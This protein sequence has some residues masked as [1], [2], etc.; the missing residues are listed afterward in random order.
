MRPLQLARVHLGAVAVLCLLTLSACFLVAGL[1]R[2]LQA[3]FDAAMRDTLGRAPAEQLDLAVRSV[4]NTRADD[5]TELGQFQDRENRF[6]KVLPAPLRPMVQP[7]GSGTSHFSAK[8]FQTPVHGSNGKTFVNLGWL[9]DADKRV[10]W[11]QGRPP[12]PP[13][14]TTFEGHPITLFEV[15]VVEESLTQMGLALGQQKIIGESDYAAVKVV[16]VFRAKNPAD[17]YWSHNFDV[18]HVQLVQQPNELEPE[19]HTTTL[20]STAALTALSGADRNLEYSWVLP[21]D[22]RAAS[23]LDVPGLRAAVNDFGRVAML[24]AVGSTSQYRLDSGLAKLVGDFLVAMATAQTVMY[25]VL[26]GLLV[27][28]IGVIVLAVQ[29]LASRLDTTLALMRARGGSLRTVAGTGA[30]V[31]ALA[32]TPSALAGYAAS[33]AVPGPVLPIVHVAPAL[34][35]LTAV[36]FAAVGLALAHR[37]PLHEK[38]SD[39]VTARPSAR[40]ITLEVLV[41]GLALVGAYLLRTRGLTT[42]VAEQGQDAFLLLVPIALTVAAA[43]ITL[44]CYPYPLKLVVRLAASRR[45]AV[46]F[47]GLTRAARAG[48]GSVLPVLILLPA[49]AVSVFAAVVSDGIGRTQV[50]ASW[51]RIGAPVKASLSREIPADAIERIRRVPGVTTVVPAQTGSVQIGFGGQRAEALAVDLGKWRRL[52]GDA[53]ISLPA[54]GG[55]SGIPVLVSP[56]LRGRG[57]F[58]IGWQSRIKVTTAGVVTAVPGFFTEGKF[59]VV[60]FETNRRPATNTLLIGGDVD[61]AAIMAAARIPE[62]SVES[63]AR[64]LDAIQN[65]PLTATVRQI[66]LIT[67]VA[68]TCYALVAVIVTLVV[69]AADRARALSFLRTL[70]LSARQA[71]LLTVLEVSPMIVTTALAGLALGLGLPAALGPGVDLSV[72]AG[73]LTVDGFGPSPVMPVA[74]AAGV[75]AVAVLGAYAHTAISRRRSLGSVLRVGDLV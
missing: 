34:V 61:P 44:R 29:L 16:G 42:N 37:A 68:L 25:L 50:V 59:M 28:A 14:K 9:S 18:L 23:S 2:T 54:T 31:V 56:E 13:S 57:T 7:Q 60:P 74:L 3:S 46:P 66:L 64:A 62:L 70:G 30:G 22:P 20:I 58:E 39:V 47:L 38:R 24:Q 72:Y 63:R 26:G 53:P 49:L 12:G 5:L 71:Q 32:A 11:V 67:M 65:D 41:I 36:G 45:P 48:F 19:K 69:G 1:P 10:D 17:R 52:I 73:G 35:L 75:T 4:S 51:Q 21:V 33:Y 15:G 27:V 8:T 6:R 55:A 40:R 43:L